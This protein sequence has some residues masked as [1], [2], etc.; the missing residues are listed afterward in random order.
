MAPCTPTVDCK[1]LQC[2]TMPRQKSERRSQTS[3]DCPV[4]QTDKRLQRS[5]A[6]NPNGRADVACPGQWTVTVRCA[7]RQQPLPMARKW[8]GAINIPQPP[9]SLASK[10][11]EVNIQDKS[12]IIHSKTQFQRSNP[13]QVPNST[14]PLS[15]LRERVFVFTWAFV[16]WIAFFLSH[17]FLKFF[18]N[19]SKRHQVCGGPC[20]V[21]VTRVI[22]ERLT[23]SKWPFEREG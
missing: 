2:G 5:T 8:L 6:P 16:S 12:Y 17:L 20:G 9:H 15:D 3:P 14:Q 13:L 22:K 1:T 21:L 23:R 10:F 18:V 11:S 7:H 4:Q 19:L